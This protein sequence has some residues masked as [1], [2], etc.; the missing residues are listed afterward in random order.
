[1]KDVRAT[2]PILRAMYGQNAVAFSDLKREVDPRDI[3][4][5]EFLE[6]TLCL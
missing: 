5:N 4:R 6:R 1:M 3:M 2:T